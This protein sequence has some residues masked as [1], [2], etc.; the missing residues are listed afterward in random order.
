MKYSVFNLYHC[1]LRMIFRYECVKVNLDGNY[2]FNKECELYPSDKECP[3]IRQQGNGSVTTDWVISFNSTTEP[4][5]SSE[6]GRI[7]IPN[8]RSL[9]NCTETTVDPTTEATID[10]TTSYT[11]DDINHESS[12]MALLPLTTESS[13]TTMQ[14]E[15]SVSKST[16]SSE[17]TTHVREITTHISEISTQS[18][19]TTTH[20]S[21]ITTHSSGTTTHS[22]DQRTTIITEKITTDDRFSDNPTSAINEQTTSN[23]KHEISTIELKPSSTKQT[24]TDNVKR[25]SISNRNVPTN[26]PINTQSTTNP[27]PV[28]NST[29]VAVLPTTIRDINDGPMKYWP[30]IVGGVLGAIVVAALVSYIIYIRRKR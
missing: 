20:S 17:I 18:S 30:G 25:S 10:E 29:T 6:C 27:K 24:S 28:S 2:C 1:R 7:E 23:N 16:H 8:L 3:D 15:A 11:T 12:T 9:I 4:T 21:D 13:V 22:T 14:M 26:R 5:L 19:D